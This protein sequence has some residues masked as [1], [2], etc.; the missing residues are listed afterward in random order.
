MKY[1][2]DPKIRHQTIFSKSG[3]FV[4]IRPEKAVHKTYQFILCLNATPRIGEEV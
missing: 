2:I 3:P 1:G 4:C